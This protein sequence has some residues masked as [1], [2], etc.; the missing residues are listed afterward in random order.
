MNNCIQHFYGRC[1]K[2]H[3]NTSTLRSFVNVRSCSA[4]GQALLVL[5]TSIYPL[6]L[7][8]DRMIRRQ[9]HVGIVR[10]TRRS[11]DH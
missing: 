10:A 4:A 6:S 7:P 8:G 2:L 5:S 3:H 11:R 9:E 1:Y